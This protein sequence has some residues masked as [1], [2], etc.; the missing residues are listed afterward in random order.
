MLS[1]AMVSLTIAECDAFS[2]LQ[3]FPQRLDIRTISPWFRS[4]FAMQTGP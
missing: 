4:S 2:A 3:P 1:I